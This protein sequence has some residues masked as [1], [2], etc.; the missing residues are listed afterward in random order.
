MT[1]VKNYQTLKCQNGKCGVG[2]CCGT[3]VGLRAGALTSWIGLARCSSWSASVR[4]PG[5]GS[6][7]RCSGPGSTWCLLTASCTGSLSCATIGGVWEAGTT[8]ACSCAHGV[9]VWF[10]TCLVMGVSF[11]KKIMFL[12][13]YDQLSGYVNSRWTNS[14]KNI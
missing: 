1:Q 5:T 14:E 4:Y 12:S 6:T 10:Y 13:V 3:W 9:A 8:C 7:G 2:S 11:L